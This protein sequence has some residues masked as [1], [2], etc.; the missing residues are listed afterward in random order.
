[1]DDKAELEQLARDMASVKVK[2]FKDPN[3]KVEEFFD[4][5]I[6]QKRKAIQEYQHMHSPV[7]RDEKYG[8]LALSLAEFLVFRFHNA[9]R[10][11][12]SDL[13]EA[14]DLE[15]IISR[16]NHNIHNE[17]HEDHYC[18]QRYK[19]FLAQDDL[20][21]AFQKMEARLTRLQIHQAQP[22]LSVRQVETLTSLLM[23][24]KVEL[25]QL[26]RDMMSV[27][28][29]LFQEPN[30]NLAVHDALILT[31]K[32]SIR[33]YQDPYSLTR[34]DS[35]YGNLALRLAM[36]LVARFVTARR[37][38]S[39]DL[40]EAKDLEAIISRHNRDLNNEGHEDHFYWQSYKWSIARA[41][42]IMTFQKL[43]DRLAR[44]QNNQAHPL[45]LGHQDMTTTLSHTNLSPVATSEL[46]AQG[47][48]LS[49]A[50]SSL[51]VIIDTDHDL[52][53][54][55]AHLDS[56]QLVPLLSP[57][58]IPSCELTTMKLAMS[59]LE[60]AGDETDIIAYATYCHVLAHSFF[61]RY[62]LGKEIP[63]LEEA[64]EYSATAYRLFDNTAPVF[65]SL[66]LP[67]TITTLLGYVKALRDVRFPPL[68]RIDVLETL[69]TLI[70]DH[71][72]GPLA[73]YW[74]RLNLGSILYKVYI[75]TEDPLH[76]E[77][78]ITQYE[79][80]FQS[81]PPPNFGPR[82][83]VERG[84]GAHVILACLL[85]DRYE[86]SGDFSD[87]DAAINNLHLAE[88]QKSDPLVATA[89]GRVFEHRFFGQPDTRL[90]L[91]DKERAISYYQSIEPE[92]STW[93]IRE[94]NSLEALL[95]QS[96]RSFGDK[97]DLTRGIQL[98]EESSRPGSGY[99][100][101]DV[102]VMLAHAYTLR[103]AEGDQELAFQCFKAVSE[104]DR[105]K[106]QDTQETE[107]RTFG[108][109][110]RSRED[111]KSLCMNRPFETPY[112]RFLIAQYWGTLALEQ[113]HPECIQAFGL[114]ASLLLKIAGIG[115]KLQDKYKRL[116]VTQNFGGR[117][118]AAAV[119]FARASLAVEWLEI[120]MSVTTR[121]IYQLRLDV[122]DLATRHPDLFKNLKRLS[123]E[124]RQ[125]SGESVHTTD[126]LSA[127]FGTNSQKLGSAY[128]AHIEEIRRKPGMENFLCPLPFPKLAKAARYGPV[129]LLS[130]DDITDRSHA[131]IILDRSIEEPISIPLPGASRQDLDILKT[132]FFRAL[133]SLGIRH[134]STEGDAEKQSERAGRVSTK[135]RNVRGQE[136]ELLLD[137]V[138]MR[139][140][141]P[142]FEVL[143]KN[144]FKSGRMWWCPT[145][146]FTELPLHAAAP[147]DCTYIPS[148]TYGLEVLL[149]ARTRLGSVSSEQSKSSES[150][151]SVVGIGNYPGRP[152]L[153]LPSVS[154]EVQI[155]SD[156]VEG[157][158]RIALHKME[159]D[160]TS[161]DAVLSAL[162]SS[163]FV[164]LA[165][166]GTQDL[167]DPLNS[168]LVLTSDG[169]LELRRILAED[170]KSA[171]FA[172]LSACQTA[173][174]VSSL[175][176]ESVHLAG[177]FM[178]AGF[179]GVVGTL[180]RIADEDAPGVVRGVYEAMQ[181]EGGL[182]IILAAEGLDRAVKRMRN[183]GVPAHRWAPFI[184]VGV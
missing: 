90:A 46:N 109:V 5:M 83:L 63:D 134:R 2:L 99:R 55:P 155:L 31:Y 22:S 51:V 136:L 53:P 166:H 139:I 178:A 96:Y 117:A 71:N 73:S 17:S 131:F 36:L 98:L 181:I 59:A 87:I 110:T 25:E 94:R 100:H 45:L 152:H 154:Q 48:P 177:G 4:T 40:Q 27:K 18:W 89:L 103:S 6:L 92:Q 174:G 58:N 88:A 37:K 54:S 150:Q 127:F 50:T 61:S 7:E 47:P 95:I 67:N 91:K 128:E 182:D 156:L 3:V 140:V 137:E 111:W 72:F 148:Y 183:A 113:D 162:K 163:Q 172:F 130:C 21:V 80:A 116:R 10:K 114:M 64:A 125:L 34:R 9:L 30:D 32:H 14:R 68:P 147:V 12:S 151:L 175:S 142:V 33:E 164:H 62:R 167:E 82:E 79:K 69:G 97:A 179:K 52:L 85:L 143:Q 118:A 132:K 168:R 123:E 35:T 160:E 8:D 84:R 65:C 169:S 23:D 16:Y 101:R 81:Q 60:D 78:V 39:S 159:N 119:K 74:W 29:E 138:W 86:L 49:N 44:L 57:P 157:N 102:L 171:E 24:E 153:A 19:W 180:W 135:R 66:I 106:P 133:D 28:P 105:R 13:R 108:I 41:D 145:D 107:K 56:S 120:G 161:V 144:N 38:E 165:C 122:E 104:E 176:N 124:L 112:N 121:Q 70:D 26:A 93:H 77:M 75:E 15:V 173:T 146:V 42:L 20:M 43:E 170:L 158:A 115:T 149:N 1:M 129:I 11:E 141:K 126:S 184:H 76:A